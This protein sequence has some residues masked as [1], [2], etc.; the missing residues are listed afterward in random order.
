MNNFIKKI[1]KA[2]CFSLLL[3]N[4]NQA[5][6]EEL[7]LSNWQW[8]GFLSQGIIDVNG[9]NFVNDDGSTS[10]ELTELGINTSVQLLSNLRFAAQAVY[11]DGGN[12]YRKGARIDYLLLDWAILNKNNWQANLYLGRFKNVHWLYSSVRDI[13]FARPSII[14]PQSV[15]FDGFRD[16]AVGGDGAA[17][18]LSYSDDD[19]GDFDINYSYGASPISK[20]Q[21]DIILSNIALGDIKQDFDSQASF[22]WRPAFSP[23]RFGLSLLHSDFSYQS[24]GQ[25]FFA[26]GKFSFKFFTLNALYEGEQWEF[27]GEIYQE[28]FVTKGFYHPLFFQ[29]HLGQGAYLQTRY[30]LDEDLT[31]L[32]RYERFYGNKK[33]KKG[34]QLEID[35]GGTIP[36]YFAFQN[37]LVLSLSYDLSNNFKLRLE[38]HWVEGGVRLTP[39]VLPNPMK[40]NQRYWQITALQLM[41]WF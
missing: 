36:A 22:Y 3:L 32:A 39:V 38:Q 11:L 24:A 25:D 17:L 29:D 30:K 19:Y 23:W 21:Q 4:F 13:P 31:L 37:D 9:S 14:L 1:Y 10:S 27:S 20:E 40:N 15:Y 34:K 35:S 16:I 28:K 7:T 12:R 18:K 33:D 8:H 26:D 2:F 5:S 6:A 41:M